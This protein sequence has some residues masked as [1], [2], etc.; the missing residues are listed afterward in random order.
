MPGKGLI[1]VLALFA[2]GLALFGVAI[3]QHRAAKQ[4]PVIAQSASGASAPRPADEDSE[5]VRVYLSEEEAARGHREG[6]L[7]S[8]VR[9]ILNLRQALQ[10]GEFHWNDEGVPPGKITVRV[11]VRRQLVSVY[12]GGHEIGAAVALYGADGKETPLGQFPILRKTAD[13]HS[14]TYDAPMPYSLWLTNDGVAM[15][16]SSVRWGRATN[17]C[18]GVPTPFARNV[19]EVA[20]VG[21][22]IEVIRPAENIRETELAD[23]RRS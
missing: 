16:G 10:Y 5:A 19:F 20:E 9:S 21:D 6:L 14:R 18:V 15:H 11:D 17:G 22:I 12:R 4:T 13:Y 1:A 7:P 2:S 3:V 23:I 8:G